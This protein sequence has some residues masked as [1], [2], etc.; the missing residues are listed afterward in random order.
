[1][2]FSAGVT[3]LMAAASVGGAFAF[4]P[5]KVAGVSSALSS[6]ASPTETYTFTKSE[7]IF[8]EALDVRK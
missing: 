4:A 1:M 8:S 2:K 6:T 3:T 5:S 7:E